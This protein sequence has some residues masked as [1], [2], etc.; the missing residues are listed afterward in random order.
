MRLYSTSC[1]LT[2]TKSAGNVI[3]QVTSATD[4]L[5][6]KR[7]RIITNKFFIVAIVQQHATTVLLVP[8]F[9]LRSLRANSFRRQH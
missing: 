6:A 8:T 2:K 4:K 1:F 9:I 3:K 5:I 7:N